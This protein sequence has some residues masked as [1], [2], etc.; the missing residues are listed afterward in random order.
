MSTTYILDG[1]TPV[2]CDDLMEWAL[3]FEAADRHVKLTEQ[4]DVMIST[5]FLGIDHSWGR[6]PPVVFETM[7]FGVPELHGDIERYRTWSEAE[8]GHDRWVAKVFKPTPIIKLEGVT[9]D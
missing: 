2:K 8:A 3:W 6:G 4:G 1:R 9:H 5:V 7:V